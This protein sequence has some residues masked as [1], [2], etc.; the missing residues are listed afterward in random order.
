MKMNTLPKV[1][2]VI[3]TFHPDKEE[4]RKLLVR[5]MEQSVKP[6]HLLIIN[7]EESFWD[8]AITKGIPEAEV[9]H[10]SKAHF[11]HAGTR[12][13][14]AGFS[15]ADYILYMT[16]DAIPVDKKL[17][18]NLLLPFRMPTVKISYARQLPKNDCG[19]IER[20]TRS[21]NYP[22]KSH[23][24][25]RADLKRF[26][27]K[28]YFCSNVCAM[29]D[30]LYLMELHGFEEPCIF[31]EDMVFAAKTIKDGNEV[32]YAAGA[33][34]LHSHNYTAS[35]QFH[36]NFDNGVSQAMH[37]EVFKGIKSENEG[38]KLVAGTAKY[39]MDSGRAYLIPK[40]I[41]HSAAK[42][43]GF[44]LGTMYTH[45]PESMILSCTSNKSF[46]SYVSPDDTD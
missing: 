11:D 2:V 1:D 30:R 34:V 45:L 33:R 27:I 6:A 16:Q 25:R 29:Y 40:L 19:I 13:M 44:K 21:F 12:N 41:I 38:K 24:R 17:I 10:I 36:R 20:F 9:F 22:D 23:V 43:L 14:G 5:L 42:L 39:L 3:P 35:Q 15:N 4:V 8:P 31:S 26:G 28:T 37:P 7:T 46:W 32:A 18:E